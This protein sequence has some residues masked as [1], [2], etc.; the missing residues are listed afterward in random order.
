[1]DREGGVHRDGWPLNT[2]LVASIST[3]VLQR[4]RLQAPRLRTDMPTTTTPLAGLSVGAHS[5]VEVEADG[6]A[7]RVDLELT[8]KLR[9]TAAPDPRFL[10]F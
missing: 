5:D 8:F 3:M 7:V 4:V 2:A 6:L 9:G 1:M 10:P